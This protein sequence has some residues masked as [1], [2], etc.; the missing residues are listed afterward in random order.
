MAIYTCEAFEMGND[1]LMI[2]IP[3]RSPPTLQMGLNASGGR[4]KGVG[5]GVNNNKKQENLGVQQNSRDGTQVPLLKALQ[6]DLAGVDGVLEGPV[7]LSVC[8]FE[9]QAL[10]RVLEVSFLMCKRVP[11]G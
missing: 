8:L 9:R 5:C 6:M 4:E 7:V 2:Y 1:R 3:Y 10:K 11:P